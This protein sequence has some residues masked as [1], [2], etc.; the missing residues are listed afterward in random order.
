MANRFSPSFSSLVCCCHY[1]INDAQL[2]IKSLSK[3]ISVSALVKS[4]LADTF[5]TG[6]GN[7]NVCLSVFASNCQFT[8]HFRCK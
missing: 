5:T 2:A 4:T 1:A 7:E 3:Q 8:S 6:F